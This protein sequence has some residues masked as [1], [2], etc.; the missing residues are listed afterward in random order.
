MGVRCRMIE[1][2]IEKHTFSVT[3]KVGSEMWWLQ[4]QAFE[5]WRGWFGEGDTIRHF[6]WSEDFYNSPK[7]SLVWT[8]AASSPLLPST[9]RGAMA[10]LSSLGYIQPTLA[11]IVSFNIQIDCQIWA[12]A[13]WSILIT[14]I[15]DIHPLVSSDRSL[16]DHR[17]RIGQILSL[18]K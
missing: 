1:V 5:S 12:R 4:R 14:V 10:S 13:F 2:L 11:C 18:R 16:G 9:G 15:I 17:C 8:F 7:Y 6:R 3:M